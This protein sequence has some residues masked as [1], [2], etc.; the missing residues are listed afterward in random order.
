MHWDG[1]RLGILNIQSAQ[2]NG[3]LFKFRAVI[4]GGW[5]WPIYQLADDPV[6]IVQSIFNSCFV[7]RKTSIR[8]PAPGK[9]RNVLV[10]T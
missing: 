1:I 9:C 10:E 4:R 5:G 2:N 7:D 6:G 3:A 8:L